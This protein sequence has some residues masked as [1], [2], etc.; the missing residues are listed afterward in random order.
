MS[1]LRVRKFGRATGETPQEMHARVAWANKRCHHCG[2]PPAML[3][4]VLAPF[5]EVYKRV[6]EALR[7]MAQADPAHPGQIP[8]IPTT[9]G[10]MIR[11]SQ[12]VVCAHCAPAAEKAAAH[13]PSWCIV[14]IDRGPDPKNRVSVGVSG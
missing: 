5:K 2:G 3:I 13:G 10:P 1:N 8:V 11:V 4:R 12:L 14:E 7:A 6:P 9:E